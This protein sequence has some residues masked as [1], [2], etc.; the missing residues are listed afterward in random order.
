MSSAAA[1]TAADRNKAARLT[2]TRAGRARFA[3]MGLSLR[4]MT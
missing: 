3:V 2:K 4:G 1:G